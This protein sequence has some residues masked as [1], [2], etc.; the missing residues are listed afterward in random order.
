MKSHLDIFTL[1][2]AYWNARSEGDVKTLRRLLSRNC[3]VGFSDS[4]PV[5]LNKEILRA[6]EVRQFCY[7]ITSLSKTGNAL[8]GS[9]HVQSESGEY[10]VG[11]VLEIMQEK[12][13]MTQEKWV[14]VAT[15]GCIESLVEWHSLFAAPSRSCFPGLW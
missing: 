4:P 2:N 12:I 3:L 11:I 13:T 5:M 7:N 8:C 1:A 14:H 6:Y 15:N 10:G 9:L